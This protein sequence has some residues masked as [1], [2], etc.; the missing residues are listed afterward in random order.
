MVV[1]TDGA[2]VIMADGWGQVNEKV[3]RI[4]QGCEGGY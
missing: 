2:I 3:I 4:A 1:L